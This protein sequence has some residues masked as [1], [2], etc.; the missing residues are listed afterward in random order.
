[1]G[2]FEFAVPLEGYF[3]YRGPRG[4]ATADPN[5]AIC[6]DDQ[7][8]YS[9]T[10]LAGIG[11]AGLSLVA[12]ARTVAGFLDESDS[13]HL[14]GAGV[15]FPSVSVRL[16]PGSHLLFALL[17]RRLGGPDRDADPLVLEETLLHLMGSLLDDQASLP[18]PR[19]SPGRRAGAEMDIDR[20]AQVKCLLAS[21]FRRPLRLEQIAARVGV[22][23][24][25]LCRTFRRMTGVA[26]HRYLN[27]LRL[28]AAVLE[29]LEPH[30]DL[31]R[32]ACRAGFSS[33]SH[34]TAAY[35]REFG[36]TPSL[37]RRMSRDSFV[38]MTRLAR[39]RGPGAGHRSTSGMSGF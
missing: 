27:T 10:R 34:F 7:E 33:H 32:I 36:T 37:T 31:S 22:S 1:M 26:V 38:S 13:R 4:R 3:H 20:I 14:D 2:H 6:F 5:T 39:G 18:G 19:P 17:R 28:R 15:S 30:A 11:D 35:R 9:T 23:P 16:S 29:L 21:E 24:Q 12:D 8:P 25:H